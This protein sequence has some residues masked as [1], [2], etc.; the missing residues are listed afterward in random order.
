[1]I[2]IAEVT[3][4][5]EDPAWYVTSSSGIERIIPESWAVPLV[6][7]VRE[8]YNYVFCPIDDIVFDIRILG[9]ERGCVKDV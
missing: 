1:M 5:H 9:K 2:K 4:Y 3:R 6:A 7:C 8:K